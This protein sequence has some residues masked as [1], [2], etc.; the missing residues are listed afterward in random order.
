MTEG[1]HGH[2]R[3]Q[4]GG[5]AEVVGVDALGQRRARGRLG[6]HEAR[7][8]AVA[9]PRVGQPGEVRASAD[10]AD[11]HVGPVAG[12][13][14]LGD[15][16]LPDHRLVQQDVVEH[17][18]QRV[19]RPVVLG[20][21]LDR[22]RDGDPERPGR[23]RRVRAPG[24]R[25]VRRRA[26][27]GRAPRLHHR[28]PV[29]LLVVARADHEHLALEPEQRARERERRSPLPRAGLRR[30]SF[31]SGLGVLVGL[32][33]SGVRLVRA[34][35]RDAFVLVVDVRRGV[36]GLLQPVRAVERAGPPLAID[37]AHG[38]G[39]LDLALG[40]HLLHN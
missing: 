27:H 6:G 39:N 5:V 25:A 26:V 3:G 9:Q 30:E 20:G 40:A 21:D 13:L 31:D 34:G 35:G 19:V 18:A 14:H 28:A 24:L 1:V 29:G 12:E 37:I 32:R 16:L 33:D 38:L 11:H 22:L 8:P 36:E 15:R 7:G 4:A 10:A 23:V 17:A 2:Q